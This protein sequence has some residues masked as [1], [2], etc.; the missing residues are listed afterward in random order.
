MFLI[1]KTKLLINSFILF[2]VAVGL[3][4]FNTEIKVNGFPIYIKEIMIV[5]FYII[6][7][8]IIF[9]LGKKTK[10]IQRDY[11]IVLFLF[12]YCFFTTFFYDYGVNYIFILY[13][14]LISFLV[15]NLSFTYYYHIRDYKLF[16]TNLSKYLVLIL[17]IYAV[18][19]PF[20]DSGYERLKGP[21]GNAATIHV[22]ILLII[23]VFL[24]NLINRY[25]S[26]FNNMFFLFISIFL[27]IMTG[28]RA[29]LV[30]LV[31]LSILIFF[32]KLSFKNLFY[33]VVLIFIGFIFFKNFFLIDRIN[34]FEDIT[35][36]QNLNTGLLIFSDSWK[37]IFF[38][39]GYGTVWQWYIYDTSDNPM[40]AY[41]NMILREGGY[42]LYHPHSVF[43]WA[44]VELGLVGFFIVSLIFYPL[45]KSFFTMKNDYL[46][47]ILIGV[48]STI[49]TFLFDYYLFKNWMVSVL[50]W[51]FY[52]YAISE[53]KYNN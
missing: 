16:L 42:L 47:V 10:L 28:S 12:I 52:F 24:S 39:S 41:G 21:L 3:S 51:L 14:L 9:C 6:S 35:R 31:I 8:F 43:L 7:Y 5:S 13:P 50:W 25:G 33:L 53:K 38:G 15:F 29:G 20:G 17:C 45:F 23:S 40:N 32:R 30:G 27:L 37:N 4:V 36:T 34:S 22:I 46:V 19:F 18:Y 26:K 2:F 11:L 44:L 49:P 1:S 48:L